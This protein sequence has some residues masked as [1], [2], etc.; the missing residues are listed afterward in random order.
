MK[1]PDFLN[2]AWTN[3][4]KCRNIWICAKRNDNPNETSMLIIIKNV[5]LSS[6]NI[7]SPWQSICI[8]YCE[9]DI[10]NLIKNTKM[11]FDDYKWLNIPKM[12]SE[13]KKWNELKIVNDT[14]IKSWDILF[15]K[16]SNTLQ[17]AC[18]T[19]C[20]L[21]QDTSMQNDKKHQQFST[22][23]VCFL[24]MFCFTCYFC[25]CSSV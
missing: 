10:I 5:T 7:T 8:A 16:M 11:Y 25:S 6:P 24:F 19:C 3:I 13:F 1:I 4:S 23:D 18:E 15:N 17:N 12:K 22:D 14:D 21:K 2:R 9:N 20:K